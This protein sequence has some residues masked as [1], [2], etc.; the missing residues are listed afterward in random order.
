[1]DKYYHNR[2][3]VTLIELILTLAIFSIIIQVAYS[4]FFVGNKSFS[5]SKNIGFAQQ[6]ARLPIDYINREIRMA[7]G[8]YIH[9]A[10]L[11][12]P[13]YK[14]SLDGTNLVK[15][16]YS[17]SS[18]SGVNTII[19]TNVDS[20]IFSPIWKDKLTD[21]LDHNKLQLVINVVEENYNKEF[22][23]LIR[24]ENTSG[25]GTIKRLQDDVIPDTFEI[26]YYTKHEQIV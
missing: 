14:L 2:R 24:F 22:S 10:P 11:E 18:D 1:M 19:S 26:I 6:N 21:D 20:M 25:G 8:V 7:K 12:Y 3:G 5:T 16:S 23:T 17:S 13:H 15:T 4:V 9:G